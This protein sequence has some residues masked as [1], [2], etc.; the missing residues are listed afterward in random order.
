MNT[1][2]IVRLAVSTVAVG[3]AL[4]AWAAR[5]IVWQGTES[6]DWSGRNWFIDAPGSNWVE[7]NN[8]VFTNAAPVG[9]V[10]VD[11]DVSVTKV[12]VDNDDY[13]F[14]GTGVLSLAG[15]FNVAADRT[16]TLANPIGSTGNFRKEGNGEL[17]VNS[18]AVTTQSL[19][20]LDVIKGT[21]RL[22]G[23]VYNLTASDKSAVT[24]LVPFHGNGGKMIV[25]GGARIVATGGA[26]YSANSGT[27]LIV[28]DGSVMDFFG[29]GEF[30]HGFN[31]FYGASSSKI[32]SLTVKDGGTFIANAYRVGKVGLATLKARGP[33]YALT[34][35]GKGGTFVI[36]HLSMDGAVANNPLG[37][38]MEFD[39]G[40]LVITNKPGRSS[41]TW[42]AVPNGGN[43]TNV[44]M[45]I[46]EG[47]LK[48]YLAGGQ[49]FQTFSHPFESG[50]DNDGGITVDGGNAFLYLESSKS[51]FN[52]GI[53]LRGATLIPSGGDGA[54]GV[55]PATPTPNVFFENSG[56]LHFGSAFTLNKN[57]T[58]Q[59]G[60]NV[61]A[62]IGTQN[63]VTSRIAGVIQGYG[64]EGH[65][66]HLQIM[67][68]WGGC[69]AIG[70]SD[71]R[72]NQ[73]GRLRVYGHLRHVEGTTLITSNMVNQTGGNSHFL[74][75]GN[76]SSFKDAT[77][78]FDIAGGLVKVVRG[79][80]IQTSECGQLIV[81]NGTFDCTAT[82]EFLNGHGSGGRVIV[83]ENGTMLCNRLRITQDTGKVD[84][85]PRSYVH[86][87]KGGV[88]KTNTFWL[89]S[90]SKGATGSVLLDGGTVMPRKSTVDFLGE[91]ASANQGLVWNVNVF[92]RSCE[93]GAVFD[94]DG[95]NIT[96]K[97]PI[98]SGAAVDGGVVKKG[99]G[100][101]TL[102]NTNQYNGVTRV[103]AGTLKFSHANG[104]P[105][106]DIEVSSAALRNNARTVELI[107]AVNLT[108]R[109]G[110]KV[111][112]VDT[113]EVGTEEFGK[114]VILAKAEAPITTIPKVVVV[115]AD[116]NEQPGG[117]WCV[118]PVDGGK[119]LLFGVS[120]G[121]VFFL[122]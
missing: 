108:F 121:T 11:R 47:G 72:T 116:G 48:V 99:L 59:I 27:E 106:G 13:D 2:M 73:I 79:S 78:T 96:V 15:P 90:G 17:V 87:K 46:L 74:L 23:G 95:F 111:R 97:N 24:N 100:T 7:G 49:Q 61:I 70:P 14:S 19:A 12:V 41:N 9:G 60:T 107:N 18:S 6:A 105:G 86:V 37:A 5:D 39:G 80:W 68:N 104:F 33:Q 92:V 110:A 40:T 82:S 71:G 31:D 102:A 20:R 45:R 58:L 62:R 21:L 91:N 77:G 112:V 29:V 101:L 55:V 118:T 16:A 94:T 83:G 30:L 89:D 63:G 75:S 84:G 1:S 65:L 67:N 81:T 51:T 115:D 114:R 53:H 22:N 25:E 119:T 54:F 109:E 28:T 34:T 42:T 57:R 26:S 98:L 88:L 38:A 32:S 10:N 43:W 117:A 36:D 52:G 103:D 3:C 113:D 50:A 122:R 66:G 56:I 85:A 120:R 35:L 69:T 44:T 8:A 4:S 76:G 64:A 93:G